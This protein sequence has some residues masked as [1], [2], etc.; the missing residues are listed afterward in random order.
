[1]QFTQQVRVTVS[2]LNYRLGP[3]MN[4]KV[5]GIIRDKGIYTIVAE[6][7]GW[8]KLENGK[9]WINLKFT[10]PVKVE[11][12]APVVGEVPISIVQSR[13]EPKY[14]THTVKG[15][16]SLWDIAEEYLGR[17]SRYLEIKEL[18]GLVSNLLDDGMVLKIPNK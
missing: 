14:R 8:G 2:A 1:M 4:Y 16:E 5:S 7:D 15:R 13:E 6:Q 9:G 18:N 10:K 12:A 3:G 17:G 11:S